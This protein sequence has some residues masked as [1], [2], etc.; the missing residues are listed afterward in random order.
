ME[1]VFGFREDGRERPEEGASMVEVEGFGLFGSN[2]S[3]A[4]TRKSS[5]FLLLFLEFKE[6]KKSSTDVFELPFIRVISSTRSSKFPSIPCRIQNIG[7]WSRYLSTVVLNRYSCIV[8][9][10]ISI[11]LPQTFLIICE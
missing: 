5:T 8:V 1:V 6:K 9:L 10:I 2:K 4:Y 3:R 11:L 7:V